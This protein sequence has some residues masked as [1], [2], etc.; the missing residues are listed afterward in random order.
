MSF[1]LTSQTTI[2]NR[3]LEEVF[4]WVTNSEN[5]PYWWPAVKE[6]KCVTEEKKGVG[7]GYQQ[8][9]VFLGRKFDNYFECIEYEPPRRIKWR[10]GETMIPFVAEMFFEPVDDKTFT[11][12]F[13]AEVRAPDAF[14]WIEPLAVVI[15]RSQ[16]NGFFRKLKEVLEAPQPASAGA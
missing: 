7:M 16:S 10:G 6:S 14:R 9:A 2:H 15:L 4:Y 5:D 8:T 1:H 12:R 11:I 3:D 13:E